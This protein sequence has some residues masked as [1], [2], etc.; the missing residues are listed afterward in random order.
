M[1]YNMKNCLTYLH[2]DEA[3]DK[4]SIDVL[5]LFTLST[6]SMRQREK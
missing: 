5:Y 3:H 4:S 2:V 1:R 6:A